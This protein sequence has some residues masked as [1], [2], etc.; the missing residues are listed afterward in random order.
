MTVGASGR[1]FFHPL[2]FHWNQ[3]WKMTRKWFLRFLEINSGYRLL[4]LMAARA[5]PT[6]YLPL[7][8]IGGFDEFYKSGRFEGFYEREIQ[9][10]GCIGKIVGGV[11]GGWGSDG[12]AG[13]NYFPKDDLWKMRFL[14]CGRVQGNWGLPK[15]HMCDGRKDSDGNG[16]LPFGQMVIPPLTL[17]RRHGHRSVCRHDIP[18]SSGDSE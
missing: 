7:A 3:L 9:A 8:S 17:G 11:G 15:M 13:R 10:S 18:Y 2:L 4:Q 12:N 16:G 1:L 6:D 14:E 5:A